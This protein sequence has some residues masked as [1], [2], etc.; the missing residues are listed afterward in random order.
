MGVNYPA[1]VDTFPVPTLPESTSLSSAGTANRAHTDHHRDLGTGLTAVMTNAALKTHGHTGADGTAK[2]LQVNTHQSADTDTA[3]GIHHTMG[4]GHEQAARGDHTHDYNSLP[5]IPFVIRTS[6]T[7]PGAPI[8]GMVV[9]E[10]DTHV[11]R[12]WDLFA[13][14]QVVDGINSTIG[15]NAVNANDPGTGWDVWYES[16][17]T[18]H[19]KM[20]TPDGAH[21][22]WTDQGD[23]ANRAIARRTDPADAVTQTDDQIITWKIGDQVIEYP[24]ILTWDG[25]SN[26]AYFRMSSDRSK[27]LHLEA[28]TDYFRLWYTTTG[29]ANEKELG[30]IKNVNT[31]LADTVWQGVLKDYTFT[32]YRQGG[33]VGTIV[34]LKQLSAKGASNRGWAVGMSAGDRVLPWFQQTTPGNVDWIQIQDVRHYTS[35]NRWSL[36]PVGALPI[37]RLRQTT[38]QQLVPNGSI[39]EWDA[40]VEDNFD[41]WSATSKTEVRIREPGVYQIEAALQWEQNDIITDTGIIVLCIN[42]VETSIRNQMPMRGNIF[43]PG[44][45]QTLAVHGKLRFNID[46]ILTVKV[47]YVPPQG[48]LGWFWTLFDGPNKIQSR[49]D[50]HFVAN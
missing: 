40:E 8:Q 38:R 39:V 44:F 37:C 19:G 43:I 48:F 23:D 21:L 41:Y 12:Q 42:G 35:V 16:G 10:T 49:L 4:L 13:N 27:Y 45:S 28:G 2:L 32:L 18:T 15:F 29:P 17:D 31:Q 30:T 9:F 33:L 24:S 20:A 25:A 7:R 11:W 14:N 46:D 36:L 5:N 26:D 47:K 22:S 1:S 6:T 3:G 50:L 34:D